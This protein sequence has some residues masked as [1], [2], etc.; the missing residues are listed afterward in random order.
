ML[1]RNVDLRERFGRSDDATEA[2]S[3]DGVEAV[4]RWVDGPALE[5]ELEV[6]GALCFDVVC[7]I[8]IQVSV[9]TNSICLWCGGGRGTPRKDEERE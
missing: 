1:L 9:D 2:S 4:E 6:S 3:R 8:P 7:P 5:G